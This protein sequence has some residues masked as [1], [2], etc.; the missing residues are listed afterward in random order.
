MPSTFEED[1]SPSSRQHLACLTINDLVAV[2]AG[3]LAMA[4]NDRLRESLRDIVLT[5]AHLDH[6]AGLPLFVDDLF[7]TL[8]EPIRV[9]ALPEVIAVLERDVF[10]WSV[11]PRFSELSIGQSPAVLY[12][13]VS[14]D[15]VFQIRDLTFKMLPA[16]HKVPS[17]GISVSDGESS[18]V[19][20]GD[21]ASLT[22]LSD[23]VSTNSQLKA[24]LV[25]CAFPN[26]LSE[27]A[28]NSHHMT[29][30]ILEKEVR[31][32]GVKCPVFVINIKPNYRARVVA[33]LAELGIEQLEVMS[34][35]KPYFW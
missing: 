1:G 34:V 25:E 31:A 24:V 6:I 28:K 18:V 33:E 14:F 30:A 16:D 21:T 32:L 9:H 13:S 20:S 35:G 11:F 2:D 10:N 8:E 3:S 7:A 19:V 22:G 5:H 17:A 12:H 29:P 27:I 26:E 23:H 4:A 15:E